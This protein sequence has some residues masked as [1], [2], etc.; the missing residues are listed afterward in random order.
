MS[1]V[2]ISYARQDRETASR[3]AKRLEAEGWTVFWDSRLRTGDDWRRVIE[4]KV[5]SACCVVALVSKAALE[6]S[7]VLEETEIARKRGVLLP[8]LLG[9]SEPPFGF[10]VVQASNLTGW[11]G[12]S[13]NPELV[14]L[15]ETITGLCGGTGT[16]M[17]W[18]LQVY[19]VIGWRKTWPALGP[20]VNMNC[21]IVNQLDRSVSLRRLEANVAGPNDL[22]YDLAWTVPYDTVERTEHVRRFE[23]TT[24]IELPPGTSEHGIQL[25][26]PAFSS[27][28]A[29]PKG[30]YS[31]EVS[32]WTERRRGDP[33]NLKTQFE[34][35]VSA[36]AAAQVKWLMQ[37]S[38]AEWENLKASDDAM[39]V[40][41][42][43]G[44]VRA[45][46]PG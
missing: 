13:E 33:A 29:W 4:T 39:G 35:S 43:I 32:G 5:R 17:L 30:D 9:L 25:Q 8:V 45:G 11:D 7:W 24:A 27:T 42:D 36:N 1:E 37:A 15:V 38:D 40:E 19:I 44:T 20:T 14:T 46:L 23:P 18:P 34:L 3:L 12:V 16:L 2:F 41:V 6:S 21:K 10:G 22:S 31:F 28:F 26:A